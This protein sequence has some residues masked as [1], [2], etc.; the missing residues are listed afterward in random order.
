MPDLYRYW[1][2]MGR[3][4]YDLNKNTRLYSIFAFQH[5][6]EFRNSSGFPPPAE[7]GNIN[8]MR[9][10]LLGSQDVTHVFSPTLVVDVKG[11]FSRFQDKTPNGDLTSTVTPASIGLNMPK[12]P[13]TTRNLLPEFTMSQSYPQ[14]VGNNF[15]A[16]V[17]NTTTLDIDFTKTWN[18]HTIHFGGEAAYH[19]WGTPGAVGRPNGYFNFGTQYTQAN[20][21]TRGTIPGVNDGMDV[22]DMLLGYPD[23]GGVDY[24]AQQW[25]TFPNV[26]FYAQDQWHVT[27]R[28]TIDIG[29]RYD[30]QF[31]LQGLGLN[32][33]MCL[34]CVNPIHQRSRL[35]GQ[36]GEG[37][38]CMGCR[39]PVPRSLHGLWR[40]TFR[41][42]ERPAQ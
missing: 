13:T 33:G 37:R 40:R 29:L 41:R 6:T 23:S 4:D 18:R 16:D 31:G 1:Q 27:S 24:N 2:P 8:N 36:P 25:T 26:A 38:A 42:Q 7:N 19:Q 20:P 21:Y 17:Y 5:G 10:E 39:K 11:S 9:Q 35:S 22:A 14:V 3:V 28:L 32:R 30:I 12:I 34:S 15:G